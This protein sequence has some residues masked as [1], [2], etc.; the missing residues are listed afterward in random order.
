MFEGPITHIVL[1]KYKSDLTW[2]DL[3]KH[4]ESF[5]ALKSKSLHPKTGKPLIQSMKAGKNRS[6]EPY[7]KGMTHGFILEFASQQDLDY[8][9]LEE[10]VHVQFSK[11]A[12]PLM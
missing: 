10:P 6:W 9:I 7:S 12:G 1:F 3:E 2:T 8:Y 11:E 5:M 4:F